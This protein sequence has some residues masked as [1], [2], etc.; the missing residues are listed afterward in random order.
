MGGKYS[1][2]A[3]NYDDK[4]WQYEL[5]TYSFIKFIGAVIKCAIK[6]KVIAIGI[7]KE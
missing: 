2:I 7:S 3:R 4:F 1:I 6:Y 5:Y